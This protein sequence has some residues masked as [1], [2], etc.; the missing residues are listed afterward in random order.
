[1]S[2]S[3]ISIE[4]FRAAA[5]NPWKPWLIASGA[6]VTILVVAVIL[7]FLLGLFDAATDE[8][9]AKRLAASLALVGAVLSAVV[10]LIGIVVKYS[11]DDRNAQLAVEAE[12]RNHIDVAIR[13][14][15]LLCENNQ[16]TTIH[17]IGGSLLALISLGELELAVS[18]LA[19]L[20]PERLVSRHVADV[21]LRKAIL[22]GSDDVKNDAAVVLSNNTEQIQVQDDMYWPIPNVGWST[23]LPVDCRRSLVVSQP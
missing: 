16:G 3:P 19:T 14:V 21:L 1:M 10:T 12:R 17:Q 15:D 13:A 4:S 8:N 6:A 22:A 18:L 5:P 23:D 20:W 9:G 7:M 11:I 2:E